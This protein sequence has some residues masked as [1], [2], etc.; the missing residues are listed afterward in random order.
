M[1]C[2]VLLFVS[3]KTWRANKVARAALLAGLTGLLYVVFKVDD[4]VLRV[5]LLSW[6]FA[7]LFLIWAGFGD[8]DEVP[9]RQSVFLTLHMTALGVAALLALYRGSNEVW[10]FLRN[11]REHLS[12]SCS[13]IGI[14]VSGLPVYLFGFLFLILALFGV[15]AR[16]I[17][18]RRLEDRP[19]GSVRW[20][21]LLVGFL[22]LVAGFFGGLAVLSIFTPVT[23]LKVSLYQLA[24]LVLVSIVISLADRA[25]IHDTRPRVILSSLILTGSVTVLLLIFWFRLLCPP[26]SFASP[27]RITVSVLNPANSKSVSSH[28]QVSFALYRTGLLDWN[29][30]DFERL[31]LLNSG[32]FGLFRRSLE[33]YAAKHGGRVVLIDQITDQSLSDIAVVIFIN[34]TKALTPNETLCLKR[35]V[36]SGAAMLVLGDH[37]GI[38]GSMEPLKTVLSFSSIRFN[39]D[40][41]VPLRQHWPGC[42]ELRPHP[43]VQGL[44]DELALQIAVGASLSVERPA[45]PIVVA[46]YG[47]ADRGDPLNAGK[48]ANM[49][50][51]EHERGESAG[52]LV[53][54][55]GEHIGKGRVIVFGDTSPFQNGALFLSQRFVGDVMAWL[56]AGDQ[57]RDQTEGENSGSASHGEESNKALGDGAAGVS[58]ERISDEMRFGDETALIDFSLKPGVSLSLFSKSSLGGLANCLARVGVVASP[59]FL[60]RDWGKESPYLFLVAPTL[61]LGQRELRW[62]ADYMS[63]GGNV[64]L[65]EGYASPQP[66]GFLL[67]YLGFSIKNTPLGNGDRHSCVEHKD[68][69]ALSYDGAADTAVIARAF[70]YPTVVQMPF[71][72]GSFTLISDGRFF[73]DENLESE[74]GANRRNIVFVAQLIENLRLKVHHGVPGLEKRELADRQRGSLLQTQKRGRVVD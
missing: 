68:A 48:G 22:T 19:K 15:A 38:G 32:M 2:L 5:V 18:G 20:S 27:R 42:L 52:D 13:M 26:N 29:T 12:A 69:W 44:K 58:P 50:N 11:M 30:P 64:I 10:F 4:T 47:F 53:L 40:S 16:H 25:L 71:G 37:T 8:R 59:A 23:A 9:R 31:G 24:A 6:V 43:I 21:V 72:R 46:R 51:T 57:L 3:A 36:T 39:F 54:V 34:P 1:A 60:A 74:R 33:R 7:A 61:R 17:A 62:L 66:S 70:G 45:F 49:G 28:T 55:A 56:I 67:S 63:Q 41:A 73:L 65:S 35:F 14:W